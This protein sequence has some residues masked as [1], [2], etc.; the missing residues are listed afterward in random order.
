MRG[1]GNYMGSIV[2]LCLVIVAIGLC[3]TVALAAIGQE[4]EKMRKRDKT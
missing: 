2:V 3:I 4:L 1:K